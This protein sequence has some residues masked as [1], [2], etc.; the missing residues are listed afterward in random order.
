MKRSEINLL[1]HEALTFMDEMKFH[2]PGWATW[3]PDQWR[4]ERENCEEIFTNQLGWDLTD[5]G[6]GNFENTGLL[7]FSIRNG[8]PDSDHKQYAEKIMIVDE[9]QVTPMHFHWKKTEDIINRG[10]GNLCMEIYPSDSEGKLAEGTLVL[11][12]DGVKTCVQAGDKIILR[13]GESITLEPRV[14]H[15]FYGEAGKGRTLVGEVSSVNDDHTDNWFL[16]QVGRFPDIEEDVAPTH[17]LVNDYSNLI[18]G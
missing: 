14:F 16:E 5:F 4:K 12:R 15:K 7:L 11:S 6:S 3:K 8:H 18:L 17:L 2:L 9:G 1:I 10:G 13:P